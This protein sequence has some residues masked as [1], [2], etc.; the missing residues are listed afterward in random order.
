MSEK[1]IIVL[2][3]AQV[4]FIGAYFVASKVKLQY[5]GRYT[6]DS[7]LRSAFIL[8]LLLSGLAGFFFALAIATVKVL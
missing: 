1:D 6:H 4:S 3:I 7:E 5:N 8:S 2:I